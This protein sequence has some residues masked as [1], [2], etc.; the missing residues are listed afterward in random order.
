MGTGTAVGADMSAVDTVVDIAVDN[1]VVEAVVV[2]VELAGIEVVGA[3]I[4]IVGSV[5]AKAV[6]VVD[7]G[8]VAQVDC[9]AVFVVDASYPNW[10]C[11]EPLLDDWTFD[12]YSRQRDLHDT[13]HRRFRLDP[14]DKDCCWLAWAVA[15]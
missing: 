9:I 10:I 2:V 8:I 6:A 12:P 1:V 7:C 13:D 5:A 14:A 15:H 11:L 4:R 3:G